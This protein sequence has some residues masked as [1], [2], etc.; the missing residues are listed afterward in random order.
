MTGQWTLL[1]IPLL[2]G[3]V[4]MA[5]LATVALK[6]SRTRGARPLGGLLIATGFFNLFYVLQLWTETP[7]GSLFWAQMQMPAWTSAAALAFIFSL[8]YANRDAWLSPFRVGALFTV[9]AIATALFFLQ[10][11][12]F[13]TNV[14]MQNELSL[15]VM[16][17]DKQLGWWLTV[18]YAY[19]MIL[20]TVTFFSLRFIRFSRV[21]QFR[22]QTLTLI[23]AFTVPV[24]ANLVQNLLGY[25]VAFASL[26][27]TVMG[28]IIYMTVFKFRLLNSVPVARRKILADMPDGFLVVDSQNQIIDANRSARELFGREPVIG[29][30]IEEVYPGYETVV[31]NQQDADVSHEYQHRGGETDRFFDVQIS[32]VAGRRGLVDAHIVRF[33]DVT[34]RKKYERTLQRQRDDLRTLNQIVRH[35]IRNDLQLI[36]SYAELLEEEFDPKY[37]EI[38]QESGEHAVEFTNTA[39]E[40]AEVMLEES[41][42][43]QLMDLTGVVRS[44]SAELEESYPEATVTVDIPDRLLVRADTMLSAAFRNLLKNAVVHNDKD[45]PSIEITATQDETHTRVRIADDGPGIPDDRK[46]DIFEH[47]EKGLDSEGTGIGLYLVQSLSK[48]YGGDIWVED[49]DPQ[50]AMFVVELPRTDD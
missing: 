37:V 48:R 26:G 25:Q 28:L 36:T 24:A 47:G 31:R 30:S 9:P 34:K 35:D 16:A 45:T 13:M 44:E 10:P 29:E 22:G 5:G 40:L 15:V 11:E 43:H 32:P 18:S 17:A 49:N 23:A 46:D 27:F 2:G 38:I 21:G 7:M 20:V 4:L 8:E 41:S 39:R 3:A 50:G 33:N 6:N 14:R 1:F 19:G 42:D 12:L